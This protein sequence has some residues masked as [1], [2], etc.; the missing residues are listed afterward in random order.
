[1]NTYIDRI[2]ALLKRLGIEDIK[3]SDAATDIIKTTWPLPILESLDEAVTIIRAS[4]NNINADIKI[5][6]RTN[7]ELSKSTT[8]RMQ[9]LASRL[10]TAPMFDEG[11]GA[12]WALPLIEKLEEM[13]LFIKQSEKARNEVMDT[14]RQKCNEVIDFSNQLESEINTVKKIVNDSTTAINNLN[15]NLQIALTALNIKP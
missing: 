10:G 1:M 5:Q 7:N 6:S 13:Y 11:S 15:K 8:A 9:K 3:Q 12:L 4:I 2:K 14:V